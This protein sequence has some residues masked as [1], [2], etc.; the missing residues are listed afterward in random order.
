M[1]SL[2]AQSVEDLNGMRHFTRSEL[3]ILRSVD[4]A[5]EE[6]A[7]GEFE[8]Y[9]R[10][11]VN[12]DAIDIAKRHGLLG[13]PIKKEYGGAGAS[14]LV[15]ALSKE[16]LGQL[17]LGLSSFFNVQVFLGGMSLQHWGDNRQKSKYLKPAAQ[18]KLILAFGLTEPEAGS[19]PDSMRSTYEK[20][21]DRFILNGT[22]YLI[23]NGSLADRVI[24]FAKSKA[25]R[26]ETSAFIV[27]T[28]STGFNA[29]R[30]KEKIG[31]LTSDTAMLELKGVEVE[32][33]DVLGGIGNGMKVAL[34][35]LMNGR[36]GVASGCIGIIEGCLNAVVTRSKERIQHGKQIG[37]HQLI[38]RH[39]AE[40]R[41]NLEMA[42]WPTYFAAITKD[43]YEKD[44]TD[45]RRIREADNRISIA[46]K[47]ASRLAFESADRAV[48]IFGG[49]GY[50]LL[51][52]VGALFL[53]SRVTRIYEGTDEIQELKIASYAL[54]EGFEAFR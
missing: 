42:R 21:G 53:D 30:L 47:I 19:D 40:I 6:M 43:E 49:F 34:S 54:G 41:Q 44:I 2:F 25:N 35:G 15:T 1:E 51:S 16:R 11:E 39:I 29:I 12:L 5:A 4:K 37:K 18:G 10:H 26:S 22:K 28:K 32:D 45:K 7:V 20:K 33:T 52:P 3:A 46:K 9:I 13:I 23:T 48:Q 50:S 31:L 36:L 8:H 27:D 14:Q 17:G 38:Q 24:V